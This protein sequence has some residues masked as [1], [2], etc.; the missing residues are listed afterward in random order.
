MA[1]GG[2]EFDALLYRDKFQRD[3]MKIETLEFDFPLET[4]GF[5]FFWGVGRVETYWNL[6]VWPRYR[7]DVFK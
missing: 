4:F 6:M 3:A 2:T 7:G 5:L 1:K